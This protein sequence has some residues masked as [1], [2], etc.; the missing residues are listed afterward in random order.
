MRER[1]RVEEDDSVGKD[2]ISWNFMIT[3]TSI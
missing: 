1:G 3:G 2:A